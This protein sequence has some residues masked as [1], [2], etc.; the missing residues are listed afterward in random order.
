[1]LTLYDRLLSAFSNA[2]PAADTGMPRL[3]GYPVSPYPRIERRQGP[4]RSF[5]QTGPTPRRV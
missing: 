3:T 4:R 2:L 5:T 1:V